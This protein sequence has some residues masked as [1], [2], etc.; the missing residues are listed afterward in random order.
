MKTIQLNLAGSTWQFGIEKQLR[1]SFITGQNENPYV[2]YEYIC[3]YTMWQ[4]YNEQ[5]T[6]KRKI[7]GG[8]FISIM[9][10]L[11]I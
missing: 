1:S 2:I 7:L 5:P 4:I 6:L 9:C 10:K 3:G 11:K 8:N